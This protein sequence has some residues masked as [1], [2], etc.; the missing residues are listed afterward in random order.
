[1]GSG[2]AQVTVIL[3]AWYVAP[4]DQRASKAETSSRS[5]FAA[6]ASD[7]ER[8]ALS[9]RSSWKEAVLSKILLREDRI[10]TRVVNEQPST[11]AKLK[12]ILPASIAR[13][14]QRRWW[15]LACSVLGTISF[16][17]LDRTV[18]QTNSGWIDRLNMWT[19][20]LSLG[21]LDGLTDTYQ[22]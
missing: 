17:R 7:G 3:L 21:Y 8:Y 4:L 11:S 22:H 19:G 16:D 5:G 13:P 14:K 2:I 6:P 9:A 18:T 15:V 1:M 10:G 20:R 12:A